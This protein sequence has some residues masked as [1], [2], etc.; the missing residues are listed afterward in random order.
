ME[1]HVVQAEVTK[2]SSIKE[3]GSPSESS[4]ESEDEDTRELEGR[5]VSAKG[6]EVN[7]KSACI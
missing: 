1:N 2:E 4:D 5:T 3:E 7:P 6:I